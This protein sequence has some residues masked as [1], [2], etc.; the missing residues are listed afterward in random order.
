MIRSLVAIATATLA[1]GATGCA[2]GD[3]GPSADSPPDSSAPD[4]SAPGGSPPDEPGP[5]L[6]DLGSLDGRAFVSTDVRQDG[7]PRPLARDSQVTLR[8]DDRQVRASAGCNQLGGAATYDGT[9]L[10]ADGPLTMTE[11]GC[12]KPLM[13][14]D[15]WLSDLL[16]SHPKV[17]LDGDYLT[18]TSGSTVVQFVDL[19][20][21]DPDRPL[22][23]TNWRLD[24]IT[25][26]RDD[27]GSASSV[28][29]GVRSTLR[30]TEAGQI[31]VETGCNEGSGRVRV[32]DDTLRITR[33]VVTLK[34]CLDERGEVERHVIRLLRGEVQYTIDG[35]LL[36][37]TRGDHGLVYRMVSN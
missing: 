31:L 34:A 10:A 11:M 36:T 37:L 8:F 26:S 33:L 19:D 29:A 18:L 9:K 27:E 16:T 7:R 23:G 5:G 15:T 25:M 14:Q 20:V 21:A 4:S 12:A 13:T 28:P 1:L 6:S 17:L 22:V 24:S 2:A 35:T 30:I 3:S 32:L